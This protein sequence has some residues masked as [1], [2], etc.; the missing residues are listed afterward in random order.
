MLEP[1]PPE[2]LYDIFSRAS[3]NDPI[4]PYTLCR[5]SH[6]FHAIATPLLYR[7]VFVTGAAQLRLVVA[8]LEAHPDRVSLVQHLALSNHECMPKQ[9]CDSLRWYTGPRT[10]KKNLSSSYGARVED[11]SNTCDQW[12]P[13]SE[14]IISQAK[15]LLAML[16]PSVLS[17]HLLLYGDSTVQEPWIKVAFNSTR[18]YPHLE[19]LAVRA[20]RLD[21]EHF[22]SHSPQFPHLRRLLLSCSFVDHHFPHF[23]PRLART[24]PLLSHLRIH[25]V[26]PDNAF[27][28]SQG[29]VDAVLHSCGLQFPVFEEDF[30]VIQRCAPLIRELKHLRRITVDWQDSVDKDIS[31]HYADVFA[32]LAD[33]AQRRREFVFINS[34]TNT[35]RRK[36]VIRELW[37]PRN[38]RFVDPGSERWV[39]MK[40]RAGYI[41]TLRV[42][43]ESGRM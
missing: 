1:L 33:I 23:V 8:Q 9:Y 34:P 5:V 3:W 21:G 2:L 26:E 6:Q 27:T 17:L 14:R 37:E 30:V 25:H 15:R 32:D 4:L 40:V 19:E 10:G 7:A 13:S 42:L 38:A 35:G 31:F 43:E 12:L 36:A 24:A 29:V 18:V 22:D 16:A 11:Y 41:N 39:P 20:H 28:V